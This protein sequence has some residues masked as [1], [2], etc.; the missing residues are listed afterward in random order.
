MRGGLYKENLTVHQVYWWFFSQWHRHTQKKIFW[1]V[2]PAR[3]KPTWRTSYQSR[4]PFTEQWKSHKS[5]GHLFLDTKK[6]VL[7]CWYLFEKLRKC[8]SN[9]YACVWYLQINTPPNA[10]NLMSTLDLSLW[11]QLSLIT[12]ATQEAGLMRARVLCLHICTFMQLSPRGS[13]SP[14]KARYALCQSTFSCL[15]LKCG[16]VLAMAC[17]QALSGVSSMSG[18]ILQLCCLLSWLHLSCARP[19]KKACLQVFLPTAG[20]LK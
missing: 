7:S 2:L 4:C 18:N 1:Q 14:V 20:L 6:I 12:P 16:I 17:E 3:I 13:Y 9:N 8:L 10:K 5:L 15:R 11:I 19:Q